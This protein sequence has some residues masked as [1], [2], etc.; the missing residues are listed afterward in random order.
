MV[1][2]VGPK[3]PLKMDTT[4]GGGWGYLNIV[5]IGDMGEV[6]YAHMV[7]SPLYIS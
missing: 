1:T 5:T 4:R 7:T 6:G 2:K 3:G